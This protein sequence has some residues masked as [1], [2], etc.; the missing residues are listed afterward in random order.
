V[1]HSGHADPVVGPIIIDFT[2]A[3]LVSM[4]QMNV[5]AGNALSSRPIGVRFSLPA[6]LRQ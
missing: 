3:L 4:Y 6:R 5:G 1:F 2:M